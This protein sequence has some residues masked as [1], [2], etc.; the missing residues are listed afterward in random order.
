MPHPC[1]I[2]DALSLVGEKWSLFVVRDLLYGR[3]RFGDIADA[4]GAPRDIL[5]ARLRRLEDAGLV[6]RVPYSE[7][8]PRSE[9]HLTEAGSDLAPV[10]L[11][12]ARWGD[13]WTLRDGVPPP[14]EFRHGRHRLRERLACDT[15][16]EMVE[17]GTISA[18]STS[19]AWAGDKAL[20]DVTH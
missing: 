16:G 11:M 5:T 9:Y 14:V 20:G 1:S 15:C 12:L 8:P 4:T 3:H 13:R 6:R 2:A 17:H 18:R 10:L 7:R 19:D